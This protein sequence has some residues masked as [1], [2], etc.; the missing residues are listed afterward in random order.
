ML[1]Q[2]KMAIV[3][4]DPIFRIGFNYS[5]RHHEFVEI[6]ADG[7]TAPDAIRIVDQQRPDVILLDIDINGAL[8][9]L[10]VISKSW[11]AVKTIMLAVSSREDLAKSA[12]AAGA[13]AYIIKGM[14]VPDFLPVIQRVHSGETYV[15]PS[16]MAAWMSPANGQRC[17]IADETGMH[18]LTDRER[19][20]L[21]L[22]ACGQTNKEIARVLD[23]SE[24]TVKFHMTVIM[25][26]LHVRNRV[27]AAL[28]CW[29]GSD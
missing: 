13:R 21:D 7:G 25:E 5:F 11:P 8:E 29:K 18:S 17:R 9:A 3:D 22:V 6:V 27:E 23:L 28:C 16:L 4:A 1:D 2:L 15:T 20:I 14:T 24:K 12:F 26:K 19:E 10:R